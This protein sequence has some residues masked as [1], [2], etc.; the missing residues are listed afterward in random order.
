MAD[1]F[2]RLEQSKLV[3]GLL[4]TDGGGPDTP[5]TD[6]MLVANFSRIALQEEYI[7]GRG[8]APAVGV[9]S[10]IKKWREP[11]RMVAEFGP[12]VSADQAIQDRNALIAY[13]RKLGDITGHPVQFGAPDPNFHVLFVGADDMD[14]VA[15]RIRALVPDANNRALEIFDRLPRSIHCLVLAFA[16]TPGGYEYGT[17][18]A[19]IR[20]EHP[21]LMRQSCIHEEVAQ[22]FGL[23]N[24][25]PRARPSIFNDDDEFALLTRHDQLLLQLLYDPALTPGMPPEVAM[26]IVERR[27]A[28]LLGGAS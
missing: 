6:T 3:R 13:A 15:P 27:A 26:P 9:N 2:R 8:L 25:S 23:A 17:A 4:R 7:R 18:I 5:F 16:N 11:V 19:V 1:H 24:D 12:S 21:D 28:A 20:A 22:G 10:R 14:L